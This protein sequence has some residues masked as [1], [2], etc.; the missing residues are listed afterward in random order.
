MKTIIWDYNGTILDDI[1][2]CLDVEQFM[3]R[4]RGMFSEYSR[5]DY[6]ELFC[7]PVIEYYKKLGYTFEHESYEQVSVEFNRLYDMGFPNCG[8]TEGVLDKI[9]ESCQKGFRNV[10]LSAC[11]HDKLLQ[12]TEHLDIAKYFTEIMGIDNDL[13]GSKI[14]MAK[15]WMEQSDVNPSECMF[16]GDS[17]HDMETAQAIGV[18][19]YLL[20]ACG[21]QS[22]RV[23]SESTDRVVHTMHEVSF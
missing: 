1:D 20:V 15:S 4:E 7:F 9:R 3:L 13:A 12:Q 23:L 2:L 5:E 16:I 10:I 21:H 14:E 17:I 22:F 8:L 11:Q 18:A 19:D 6:R